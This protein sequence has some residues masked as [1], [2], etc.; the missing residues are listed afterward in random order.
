MTSEASY[1]DS[2]INITSDEMIFY[3]Y[4]F[5]T[6]KQ[7]RVKIEDIEYIAVLEPT[8]QNGKW[9]IHGTG[10]FKVWFPCDRGRPRRDR[11]FLAVLKS[12]WVS[13][14]F[15]AEDGDA[16]ERLLRSRNLVR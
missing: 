16:V 3:H 5:P 11:I 9:R 4:Y 8:L 13:I 2:L 7:K 14:G 12:Q 6:R 15:T 1:R 10:N